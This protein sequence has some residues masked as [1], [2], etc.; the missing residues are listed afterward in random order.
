VRIPKAA[1]AAFGVLA[2][3]LIGLNVGLVRQDRR[4]AA[5]TKAYEAQMHL[6]VGDTVPP[7]SGTGPVGGAV[8]VTYEPAAPKT[9]LLVFASSC[10]ACAKNWPAWQSVMSQIDPKHTRLVGVSLDNGGISGQYL[11]QVGMTTTTSLIPDIMSVL[12]YRFRYTPQTIL[13]GSDSKVDGIWSGVLSVR[14]IQ[15]IEQ[16]SLA[17]EAGPSVA[18]AKGARSP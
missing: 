6:K 12:G 9:L 2:V 17:A 8:M 10:G 11:Q 18:E 14:Q 13:I 16:E 4:L 7:L 15:E 5:T 1:L 3:L